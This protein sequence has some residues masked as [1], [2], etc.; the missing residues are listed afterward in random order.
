MRS[1]LLGRT[2]LVLSVLLSLTVASRGQSLYQVPDGVST[3]WASPENRLAEA[4]Q[5]G[6]VNGGR[7]GAAAVSLKAN[8]HL[9][10]AESHGV[11][12]TIR[13]IWMTL[14]DRSPAMLRGLKIEIFWDGSRRAAVS[15]PMGDFFV[16]G[17][18]HMAAFQSALFSS[19]EGKSFDCFIPMPFKTGMKIVITN[20]SGKD[21]QLLFY[22]VDYTIGDEHGKDDLYF[23]AHFFHQSPTDLQHDFEVLPETKGKGRFLGASFGVRANQNLYGK[24]WWGEGEVKMYVDG[25][26]ALPTL[27]GTGTEDYVGS[28]W[29]LGQFSHIYQGAPYIDEHKGSYSF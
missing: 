9:V 20:E 19:P 28:G 17:S 15:A 25:D 1:E 29:G 7:K 27:V 24:N 13:R 8:E 5:G 4:G 22:D 14:S 23:H 18:G 16:F 3:R 21:L 26:R 10:L 6:H 11:S 12:G 2:A